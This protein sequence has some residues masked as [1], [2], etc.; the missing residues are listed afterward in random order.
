MLEITFFLLLIFYAT[1]STKVDEWI[2]ITALGFKTDTPKA[3]LKHPKAYALVCWTL[4]LAALATAFH[5][6]TLPWY[7]TS[8]A[9]FAAWLGGGW[10]GRKRAYRTYRQII[11]EMMEYG[12]TPEQL[13]AYEAASKRT[14]KE[15]AEAVAHSNKWGIANPELY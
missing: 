15:L 7:L 6:Q 12:E 10:L 9:L 11:W 2:T 3:F 14:D 13:V 1:T 4:F 5:V 8:A